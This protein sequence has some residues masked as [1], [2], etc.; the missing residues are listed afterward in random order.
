MYNAGRSGYPMSC[1]GVRRR[2]RKKLLSSHAATALTHCPPLPQK[3]A[4]LGK[5][6]GTVS[7]CLFDM[8]EH[9]MC[10]RGREDRSRQDV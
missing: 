1:R 8:G 5:A 10:E 2:L 6:T 9:A 3:Q 7:L 4:S